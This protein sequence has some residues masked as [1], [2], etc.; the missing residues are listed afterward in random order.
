MA[1]RAETI[2]EQGPRGFI[3]YWD[4]QSLLL[5]DSFEAVEHRHYP[6]E[7]HIGLEGMFRM[8]L[9]RGWREFK[10][11][12]IDANRPH[13]FDGR[14]GWQALL[15]M[16]P[17][18]M[19]ALRL[20]R[21]VLRGEAYAAI[22][23]ERVLPFVD[24]LL[25][26]CGRARSIEEIGTLC[27]GLALS[28]AGGGAA[29]DPPNRRM[30]EIL[31]ILKGLPEKRISAAELARR[32]GLS[33]SRLAHVIKEGTGMPTRQLLLWFRL[34]EAVE[35]IFAGM[36]FTDAAYEAGFADSSHLSRTYKRMCGLNLSDLLNRAPAVQ[37]IVGRRDP[38][39]CEPSLGA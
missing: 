8:D 18:G 20:R 33:E 6:L 25:G 13:R 11:L 16:D 35:R 19:S 27:D 3:Y 1:P 15:M 10:A 28:I 7:I 34:M 14:E 12:V 17:R 4:N 39:R 31:G 24:P 29:E 21:E 2:K 36:S 23:P 38:R 26:C 22:D 32:A 37:V 30:A 9:G 5:L